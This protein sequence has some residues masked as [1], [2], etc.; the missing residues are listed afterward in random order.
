[1]YGNSNMEAYITMCKI[2]NGSLLCGSGNSNGHCINLEGWGG[3]GN[4]REVRK[5]G[6]IC[7]SMANSC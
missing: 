1:M 7:I 6:H 2:D 5:G 4:E 3:K